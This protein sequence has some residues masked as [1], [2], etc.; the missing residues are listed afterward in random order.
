MRAS[1]YVGAHML[2]TVIVLWPAGCLGII[3]TPKP[4]K[5]TPQDTQK[6]V[7]RNFLK[8]QFQ[9][10]NWFFSLPMTL[11]VDIMPYFNK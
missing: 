7:V 10:Y 11:Y 2:V 3:W 1:T 9:A 4:P 6:H 5:V 8:F